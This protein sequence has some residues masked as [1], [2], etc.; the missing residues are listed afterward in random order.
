MA[1]V[2]SL[3][4]VSK[5]RLIFDTTRDDLLQLHDSPRVFL[6]IR[7]AGQEEVFPIDLLSAWFSPFGLFLSYRVQL[8]H[9]KKRFS[10]L[11]LQ[12]EQS[13]NKLSLILSVLF[14]QHLEQQKVSYL[15][16]WRHYAAD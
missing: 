6:S 14:L 15:N 16:R 7:S 12:S 8:G 9:T 11:I 13:Y 5:V 10:A 1:C 2:F 3:F 4:G